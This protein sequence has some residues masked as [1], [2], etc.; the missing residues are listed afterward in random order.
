MSFWK[1][2]EMSFLY[3]WTTKNLIKRWT[4]NLEYTFLWRKYINGQYAFEKKVKVKWL[5]CVQLFGTPWTG[6]PGSSVHGIFQAR[7]LEWAAMSFSNMNRCSVLIIVW[8]VQMKTT[9]R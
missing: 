3:D 8:E 1:F 2:Y 5:S 4:K 7:V 6:L 9:V